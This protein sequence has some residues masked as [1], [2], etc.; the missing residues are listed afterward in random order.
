MLPLLILLDV[1][2]WNIHTVWYLWTVQFF[3]MFHMFEV[4][5]WAKMW[6]LESS[7][8]SHSMFRLFEVRYFGV[9]SKTNWE[10]II[11][12]RIMCCCF[13]L[14][15]SQCLSS[16][17]CLFTLFSVVNFRS[18]RDSARIFFR[19]KRKKTCQLGL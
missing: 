6:C 3:V 1:K 11:S 15:F 4:R 13:L 18:L 19:E 2:S 5:F 17:F 9:R 16:A 12:N 10:M 14:C 8:V 7:M